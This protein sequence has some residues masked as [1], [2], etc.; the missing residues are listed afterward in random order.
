MFAR[1]KSAWLRSCTV[2]AV[3]RLAI[4][5][6]G[7]T[8]DQIKRD[9]EAWAAWLSLALQREPRDILALLKTDVRDSL[10]ARGLAIYLTPVLQAVPYRWSDETSLRNYHFMAKEIHLAALSPVLQA[11]AF[12]LIGIYADFAIRYLAEPNLAERRV[13]E[14]I[15][16]TLSSYN[17]FILKALQLLP[18][19]DPRAAA[20]F[21]RYQLRDPVVYG[22]LDE[23][24]GYDPFGQLLK[25]PI[26]GQWKQ[27]ADEAM[28]AIVQSE[29]SGQSR[30]RADWEEALLQYAEV[31]SELSYAGNLRYDWGLFVSQ[32]DFLLSFAESKQRV[33]FY[34][35]YLAWFLGQLAGEEYST[36]RHRLVRN[37]VL[38]AVEGAQGFS[39]YD[40]ASLSSAK[41]FITEYA[42][43]RVLVDRLTSLIEA[44]AA[45]QSVREAINQLAMARADE[46]MAAMR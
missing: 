27:R 16:Q 18:E 42:D 37:V 36:L 8:G 1:T 22:N 14:E 31:L 6:F 33:Y 4:E 15:A 41:R 26:P 23:A 43:D 40:E 3:R 21:R 38:T 24:S 12:E 9:N 25:A 19:A 10:K 34:Q 44:Y 13:G 7:L 28:R 46:V 5:T 32:V 29:E 2:G 30:P 11:F 39:V 17:H 45:Q 35:H 20:L